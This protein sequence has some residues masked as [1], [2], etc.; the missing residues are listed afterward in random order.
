M[1]R[2][3]TEQLFQVFSLHRGITTDT[4][5]IKKDDIF[6]ALKGPNYNANA[7]AEKAIENG[8][9]FAVVDDP[10]LPFHQKFL[11][12]EDVLTS[13]QDLAGYYRN[14]LNIPVIGITGSNGKTTTKELVHAVL[15]TTFNTSTTIGNLNNHIGIPI[16]LL[17]IPAH[18]E[19][20]V[21]EMG[22]NHLKEI[23]GYCRYA[24]PTHGMVTNCGK[25][26][27]EGFGSVEG[28]RAGK[29]ELFDHLSKSGG[30]AFACYDYEYFHEMVKARKI[31][32]LIWYGQNGAAEVV[33]KILHSGP[34]LEVQISKGF[35]VPINVKTNLV[36]D[37][38]F[39]NV[40]AAVTIGRHFG[41]PPTKIQEAIENYRPGNSRSQ[42]V[43]KEGLTIILDA[44]NANPSSMAAAIK[45]FA[46][47]EAGKKVLML[48]SM[49]ELGADSLAEHKQI[50]EL[51]AR[52]Q[53]EKVILVGGWFEKVNSGYLVFPTALDARDWWNSHKIEGASILLKGSRSAGMEKVLGF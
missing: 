23:E 53:W 11:L 36:G 7:F 43:K 34:Y 45:N 35:D 24:N 5:N 12:V 47:M 10:T 9:A 17:R 3:S 27:L 44:Y 42:L 4:R 49:A 33:G 51:I 50:V 20:A 28:I 30:L 6:F 39:N 2:V 1:V 31:S 32:S 8:A 26:H 22:A 13:L 18:A 37:Y 25:A 29:G 15:S 52:Y 40:L 38:N 19:I 21:V 41:V 14:S 16:T 46:S 48:G